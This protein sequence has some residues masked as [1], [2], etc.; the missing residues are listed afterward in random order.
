MKEYVDPE[1]EVIE[2]SETDV[3][4][5]SAGIETSLYSERDGIWNFSKN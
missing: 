4:Q 3:I 5:A 1:I 2:V